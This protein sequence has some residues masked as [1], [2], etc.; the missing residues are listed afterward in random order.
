MAGRAQVVFYAAI[1]LL[2]I[3]LGVWFAK[4]PTGRIALAL[5]IVA[6]ASVYAG[7]RTWLQQRRVL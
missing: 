3:D 1:A 5:I 2:V 7:V 6:A 4:P